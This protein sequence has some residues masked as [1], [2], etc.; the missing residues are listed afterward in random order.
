MSDRVR[1]NQSDIKHLQRMNCRAR[2]SFL[3]HCNPDFI[4][5]IC[6]CTKNLLHGNVPVSATQFKKLEPYK[7]VLRRLSNNKLTNKQR[8]QL[9]V[10]QNGGFLGALLGPIATLGSMLIERL[11]G[12]S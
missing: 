8:R 1:R 4:D 12:R 10:K 11:T 9:L 2:K 5:C 7:K 3:K 6:E